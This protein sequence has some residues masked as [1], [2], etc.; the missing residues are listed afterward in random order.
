MERKRRNAIWAGAVLGTMFALAM[1]VISA[2]AIEERTRALSE[3]FHHSYPL[4]PHG[5]VALEN[6]N[7]A[8]H[9]T[10]WDRNEVKVDAVKRADDQEALKDAEIEVNDRPD[11]LSIRTRY[12]GEEMYHGHGVAEVEY[13]L[14][15]PAGARL[16]E[17]KLI[18]GPLEIS[19]MSGEVRAS[20]I[21]GKLLAHGLSAKVKLSTVNG[22]LEATFERLEGNTIDLASVNGPL[23]IT[24]PSDVKA[25]IDATTVHGDINNDF[26]LALE[27]HHFVG[28]LLRGDLGGG[29]ST[30]RLSNVNGA[31]DIAHANDGR[32]LSP[33]SSSTKGE[34]DI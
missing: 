27:R 23:R 20:C 1:N 2:H 25:T 8:V 22:P 7:G 33:A 18:N 17:I 15:V 31:I 9:I 3:E 16:D 4:T 29:G 34:S 6:I 5:T 10:A 24:L 12:R 30:V 26:G 21:N 11:S 13:T 14:T 19:G 32:A 28:Q